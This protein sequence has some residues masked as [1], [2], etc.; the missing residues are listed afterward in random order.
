MYYLP[1]ISL[2]RKYKRSIDKLLESIRKLSIVETKVDMPFAFLY[3]Y[4]SG[5]CN[6]NIKESA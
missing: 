2:W 4:K 3:I 6:L 5:K 1:M